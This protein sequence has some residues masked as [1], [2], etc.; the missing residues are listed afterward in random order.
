MDSR[1]RAPCDLL[2]GTEVVLLAATE[3]GELGD[4]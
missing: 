3:A 2:A 4:A 1:R